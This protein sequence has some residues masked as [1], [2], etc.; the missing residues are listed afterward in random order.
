MI[1]LYITIMNGF[2][3][4]S[5]K[6]VIT[7]LGAEFVESSSDEDGRIKYL[8]FYTQDVDLDLYR[9]LAGCIIHYRIHP[10]AIIHSL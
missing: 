5:I 7:N 3:S 2:H 10:E 4:E 6:G 9:N 8:G 1:T